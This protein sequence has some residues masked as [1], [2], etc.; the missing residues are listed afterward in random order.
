MK[1]ILMQFMLLLLIVV[2]LP[3][4]RLDS[5]VVYLKNKSLRFLTALILDNI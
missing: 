5:I 3:W 4:N 2:W 1:F